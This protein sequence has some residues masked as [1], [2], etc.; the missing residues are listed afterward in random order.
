MQL[1]ESFQFLSYDRHLLVLGSQW[2]Y[3]ELFQTHSLLSMR[4]VLYRPVIDFLEISTCMIE[5]KCWNKRIILI[6]PKVG[7]S[8]QVRMTLERLSDVV[9][10][11]VCSC[12]CIEKQ[13][14]RTSY[15]YG[16]GRSKVLCRLD[17][18]ILCLILCG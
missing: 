2:C 17:D 1:C 16:F 6:I 8:C 4:A 3:S 18:S 7:Q 5:S 9:D 13:N 10:A 15:Q 12:Q 11:V 14:L